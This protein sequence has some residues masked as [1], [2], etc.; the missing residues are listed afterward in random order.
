MQHASIFHGVREEVQLCQTS[1][2]AMISMPSRSDASLKVQQQNCNGHVVAAF[3]RGKA[4]K[5]RFAFTK[6][7]VY[8]TK[9]L[10]TTHGR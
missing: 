8:I 9:H 7:G 2:F 1:S 10:G 4:T 6:A 3:G 5:T